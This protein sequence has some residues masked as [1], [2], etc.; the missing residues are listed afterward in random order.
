MAEKRNLMR[1]QEMPEFR[2]SSTLSADLIR[3]AVVYGDRSAQITIR[4]YG[5]L[6]AEIFNE[7]ITYVELPAGK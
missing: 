2:Q 3:N 5:R 7:L 1:P 6:R 4:E